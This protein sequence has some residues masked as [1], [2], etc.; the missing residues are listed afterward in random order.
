LFL[1]P[2]FASLL[3]AGFLFDIPQ[4]PAESA[5]LILV[6][7][8]ATLLSALLL[9]PLD[10]DWSTRS[11]IALVGR[12]A[13]AMTLFVIVTQ[14]NPQIR[15]PIGQ[16]LPI[17]AIVFL[18][19]LSALCVVMAFVKNRADARLL[20]FL[21]LT[22]SISA[23]LWLGPLA[24]ATGN[25][26]TLTN[27]IVGA[28]PLSAFAVSLNMDYLRTSWFYQHSVLGSLRYDYYSWS[29]YLTTLAL[30]TAGFAFSAAGLRLRRVKNPFNKTE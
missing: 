14:I 7:A 8:S 20:V 4:G 3:S 23:C 18:L 12:C 26:P 24:E 29:S 10:P 13:M 17:A 16:L 2:L 5:L 6:Y 25:S 9:V 30:I 15:A 21:V 28:N 1:V 11:F 19:M 22:V 27:L